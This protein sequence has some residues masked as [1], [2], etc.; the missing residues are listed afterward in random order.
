MGTWDATPFGNDEANDWAYGLDDVD[1][2]SLIEAAFDVV[3]EGY[4]ESFEGASAIAAAE[5]LAWLIGRPGERNAYTEKIAV[6]AEAH[7]VE[8]GSAVIERAVSAV[9]RVLS[10]DS[11]L[12]ELWGAQPEWRAAVEG[13]MERLNSELSERNG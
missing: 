7:P 3:S 9:Q 8:V 10:P 2:L 1:D 4:I 12:V 11:E 13:V 5:V 6:W